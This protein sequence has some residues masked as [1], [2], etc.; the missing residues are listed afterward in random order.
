MDM[1]I[2]NLIRRYDKAKFFESKNTFDKQ[3][4]RVRGIRP[5]LCPAIRDFYC[6]GWFLSSPIEVHFSSE[7]M[8]SVS[9]Y[10][11]AK[12]QKTLLLP[13]VIGDNKSKKLYARIDTGFSM[14]SSHMDVLAIKAQDESMQDE[15]FGIA[16]VVYPAGYRGPILIAAYSNQEFTLEP[17][18]PL[19]HCIPLSSGPW[20][21]NVADDFQH[22][23][24]RFEGR[25]YHAWE[26]KYTLRRD[27]VSD[28]LLVES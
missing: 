14:Q 4:K 17:N 3:V 15:C 6:R 9:I 10:E 18:K 21:I 23:E 20:Q 27:T 7:R 25:L 1:E 5:P 26:E 24:D 2:V 28:K 8:F 16:P 12:D 11:S 22:K 13:G 19:L